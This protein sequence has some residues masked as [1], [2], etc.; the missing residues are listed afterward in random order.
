MSPTRMSI[1]LPKLEGVRQ[2]GKFAVD[3]GKFKLRA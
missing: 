3:I 1:D 2:T